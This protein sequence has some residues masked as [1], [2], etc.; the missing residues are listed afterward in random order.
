MIT[1]YSN[2]EV[3]VIT[4]NNQGVFTPDVFESNVYE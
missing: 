1:V 2:L 3:S 4:E